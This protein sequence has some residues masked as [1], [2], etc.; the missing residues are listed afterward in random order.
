MALIKSKMDHTCDTSNS[1][2]PIKVH[3]QTK[4]IFQKSSTIKYGIFIITTLI[5]IIKKIKLK[6]SK[7]LGSYTCLY[8]A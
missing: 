8:A 6:D 4:M 5:I 7:F 2:Y 1:T 3:I